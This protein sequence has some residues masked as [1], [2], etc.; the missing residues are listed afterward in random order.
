MTGNPERDHLTMAVGERLVRFLKTGDAAALLAPTVRA[1]AVRLAVL[2]G[3]HTMGAELAHALGLVHWYRY[4]LLNDE[5]DADDA[6]RASTILRTVHASRADAVP[7]AVRYALESGQEMT[8][9]WLADNTPALQ[10]CLNGV[11]DLLADKTIRALRRAAGQPGGDTDGA[12]GR[13]SHLAN[14]AAALTVR[15]R[16]GNGSRRGSRHGDSS[17]HADST[18][19]LDEAIE[20]ARRAVAVADPDSESYGAVISNLGNA[21]LARHGHTGD[22]A[23]LDEAIG[24]QRSAAERLPD[25]GHRALVL[26]R[27]AKALHARHR[28]TGARA[29]LDAA[30]DT[31]RAA[32]TT[33]GVPE[34]HLPSY[35]AS[36]G[37]VLSS[38]FH[39]DRA[40]ADLDESIAVHRQVSAL[41]PDTHRTAA[42]F[43]GELGVALVFRY[44][45]TGDSAALD[46]AIAVDRRAVVAAGGDDER[47]SLAL[48][49]LA[50]ALRV[51]FQRTGSRATLADAV[52][53]HREAAGLAPG[54]RAHVTALAHTLL[55]GYRHTGDLDLLDELIEVDR[56][57]VAETPPGEPMERV[58]RLADLGT[59]LSTRHHR[60]GD[61]DAR[62]ESVRAFTE[63]ARILGAAGDAMLEHFDGSGDFRAL[64]NA[65]QA[66]RQ[67]LAAVPEDDDA[68]LSY[69]SRLGAL[70]LRR[71]EHTEDARALDELIA[72]TRRVLDRVP[73]D[74]PT[75]A[76]D[77]SNL[78]NAL[79]YR[80]QQTGQLAVLDEAI[81][82]HRAAVA[83]AGDD[84]QHRYA[85]RNNLAGALR[86]RFDRTGDLALLDEA[87][88][89]MRDVVVAAAESGD[90]H[91]PD[92]RANLGIH[93]AL[94]YENTGDL[95]ALDE[96]IAV[97]RSAVA[98]T[99]DGNPDRAQRLSDLGSA[100]MFRYERLGDASA[101]D[102]AITRIG[103]GVD[104]TAR[105]HHARPERLSNL[106]GAL[107]ARFKRVREISDL[108]EAI[109]AHKQAVANA[110]GGPD[111]SMCLSNLG[112][113]LST[114]FDHTGD[115][116]TLDR[117]VD[118]YRRAV[119]AVPD[120][121]PR[122]QD[123]LSNLSN[124]LL[125]RYEQTGELAALDAAVTAAGRAVEA[126]PAGH[127]DRAMR[128]TQLGLA[129]LRR[130]ERS[131]RSG[132]LD[133]AVEVARQALA[134]T[135]SDHP[136][137]A[138][139]LSN[140]GN[141]LVTRYLRTLDV[142]SLDDATQAYRDAVTVIPGGRPDPGHLSNLSRVL[143]VRSLFRGE[144]DALVEAA[145]IG[146]RAA[147]ATRDGQPDAGV[148]INAGHA[149]RAWYAR[150]QDRSVLDEALAA[151]A[152]AA[153]LPTASTATRVSAAAA[154]G[155]LALS[156][157]NAAAADEQLGRAVALLPLVAARHLARG[158][159]EYWLG[160]FA[161]LAADAAAAAIEAGRPE[162][163]LTLLELGR[164]ILVTQAI[165]SRTDL[166]ELRTAAP[167]LAA[168]FQWLCGELDADNV[169]PDTDGAAPDASR[170]ADQR[171]KLAAELDEL[172]RRIRDLPGQERFL[173]PPTVEQ[174]A[175]E[176]VDGPV[177]FVNP[178]R[179]R[180]DA[181]ILTPE[182]VR[183]VPLPGI[184]GDIN[185]RPYDF[186]GAL[187]VANDP[188][189]SMADRVRAER[190]MGQTLGWLW[191]TVAE[192]VLTALG[193]T[194]A[195]PPGEPLPR[196]WWAPG[197]IL[198]LLPLH[199]AGHHNHE[200]TARTVMDRVVSSYTPTVRALRYARSRLDAAGRDE[201]VLVVAMPQ[202]RG[203]ADLPGAEREAELLT[204]RFP[205]ARVLAGPR[206]TRDT[207][208]RE[209]AGNAVAHFACHAQ[210][211]P[212]NPAASRLL[213]HD[214][215]ENPLTVLDVS[216]LR[217]PYAR[218]AF[219]SAC[220]T[221]RPT[222]E[223]ADEAVHIASAFQLAGYA[224]VVG[225]LW[226]IDD[227]TAVSV[228]DGVYQALA[229]PG[230]GIDVS[231]AAPALH[232]ATRQLRDLR[233]ETPS[234]WAGYVHAGA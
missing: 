71:Y 109:T 142:Q 60:T 77:L 66:Y 101:L 164:G 82:T 24:A 144:H 48:A 53:A 6:A 62:R 46:E 209:L 190:L 65:E 163:A 151:F 221:A 84:D 222:Q 86:A 102:E 42:R 14:L 158:D 93:L 230:T 90:D 178:S 182:G 2:A 174:L 207:I 187:R 226:P 184:G 147:A 88:R 137:R 131:P 50:V 113:A 76:G 219:L 117:A 172:L 233:R 125:K 231:R 99:P 39:A 193:R 150:S 136:R 15:S 21:L 58:A 20:V 16:R 128:L 35:L 213:V 23:D 38:R 64:D 97:L 98:G 94:R 140:L 43:L 45:Q 36:L 40:V 26:N 205:R 115:E 17:R 166:T 118:A 81:R 63:A 156:A 162:R 194:G 168:R 114:R 135:P 200:G 127:P 170:S 19:D 61:D 176:A 224:H 13:V 121:H 195:P 92:Y 55:S 75:R 186:L 153:A 18:R 22:P 1:D 57:A 74:D 134:A 216:R 91:L 107:T 11:D 149:L 4:L 111:R 51:S 197:G 124:V 161:G 112:V 199:A 225:T 69:L 181:L 9:D 34:Q 192:P 227:S 78:G 132:G 126:S 56:R 203:A 130:H 217:L 169:P 41:L 59:A 159:I 103:A 30:I 133:E 122:A 110:T 157:G 12:A 198:N 105:N 68:H 160:H 229:R 208:M 44:G 7:A 167:D 191:D 25:G 32:A 96:S 49:N 139:R 173:L 29:D 70:L 189:A 79:R 72:S 85:M 175:A 28:S 215:A 211:D 31:A 129:L 67:A 87:L 123:Y 138:R 220:T 100:L 210:G 228:A 5:S 183:V 179:Y 8:G 152:E 89:T 10:A 83:A 33:Q 155:R 234:R 154:Y 202:T 223:L 204:G 120:G 119:E 73:A 27:L 108:D 180:C 143:Q 145:A 171:R 185:R 148:L 3:G 37:E 47:R 116:P 106:G 146:R 95:A 188:A 212:A 206:A 196:M 214:H 201:R 218:L 141:A 165:E 177:V 54:E 80:Y 104:A 232:A 52:S